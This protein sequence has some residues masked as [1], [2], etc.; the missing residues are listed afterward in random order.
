M[1]DKSP[2]HPHLFPL[3]EHL[4]FKRDSVVVV[5]G[6]QF[7]LKQLEDLRDAIKKIYRRRALVIGI[8][9]GVSLELLDEQQMAAAGWVRAPKGKQR[10]GQ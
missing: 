1:S 7:G 6:S 2:N 3:V 9:A 8:P 4:E 10:N 5:R